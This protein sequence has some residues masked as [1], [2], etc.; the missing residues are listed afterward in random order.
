[1]SA[2]LD[3]KKAALSEAEFGC[4]EK[5]AEIKI[6]EHKLN[7]N[8]GKMLLQAELEIKEAELAELYTYAR[9]ASN[10]AKKHKIMAEVAQINSKL[11]ALELEKDKLNVELNKLKSHIT[12]VEKPYKG[13][14]K[15]VLAI[16]AEVE[17]LKA[18]IKVEF[19]REIDEEIAEMDEA[20]YAVRRAI[21]Q[22]LRDI[23]SEKGRIGSGN[24]EYLEDLGLDPL[25]IQDQLVKFLNSQRQWLDTPT[26]DGGIKDVS[27]ETLEIFV[28]N[29]AEHYWKASYDSIA[30]KGLTPSIITEHLYLKQAPTETRG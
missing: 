16:C 18:A 27:S 11:E 1:M 7:D 14:L 28:N 13:C 9:S 21:T 30:R 23:R 3:Q 19:G 22:S 17:N 8:S 25:V 24:Q 15:D 4:M 29:L 2:Q 10:E 5:Y 20:K 6:L 26:K 12:L